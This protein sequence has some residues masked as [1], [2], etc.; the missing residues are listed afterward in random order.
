MADFWYFSKRRR[1][2]KLKRPFALL[3]AANH[4]QTYPSHP[5]MLLVRD[6][7]ELAHQVSVHERP[8]ACYRHCVSGIVRRVKLLGPFFEEIR[9]T[10]PPLPPSALLAFRSMHEFL[11]KC[12]LLVDSCSQSSS[13]TWAMVSSTETIQKFEVA[14]EEM[15]AALEV[16]PLSLLEISDEIKE[17]VLLLK[18]QSARGWCKALDPGQ[19]LLKAELCDLM[20][21]GDGPSSDVSLERLQKLFAG[22]GLKNW[23]DCK[24]E[25][26]GLLEELREKVAS[27]DKVAYSTLRGL[28][29]LVRSTARLLYRAGEEAFE[30]TMAELDGFKE[31]VGVLPDEFRCPISLELMRNPV[32]IATGQTYDKEHIQK[33]IAAGHFTCPTS[34][35]KLIHLGLIPNYALRS[36]IFHWCDDNNVSLEL[37]DAGFPDDDISNSREALE[38]AKTTSAF[39]VGKLATGSIDVQRQVAYELRLLAKNGTENRI[40]IAE[41]G[42]IPFLVP[43]LACNDSKTQENAVTALLNLSIYDNNKKLIMAANALDPILSVVEQ[44]LSMEARQNAAAAIFSLSSTDEH[45]IRIGSRAVA[46]PALVTLLLEGSLQ[47]KKDA[48]SA[49]FNLL[50]YPGNRARVV[51]AGAIEV[52]MAMLSKDGDVQDDALAVLALLGE[53]NEGLKAL[54][55][56][57]LAIPLLVNLLRTGSVKGKENSLSVLL[58]LCKHGGDMIRDCL[59]V[60]QQTQ[61]ESR[62]MSSGSSSALLLESLQELIASGSPRARRKARSLL[63]F[64]SVR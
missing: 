27:R 32:T 47:A 50:L 62:D 12:N 54:S 24:L 34:G 53:S 29:R 14:N 57:L 58:A 39:L 28:I 38:I 35:Q 11:A 41:A 37:F 31:R 5:G 9:D 61:Q 30:E 6:L 8:Q 10:N 55:D 43:L 44:G 26:T 2:M 22:L 3:H 25:L 13:I 36:L 1:I 17:H 15:A 52:L 33:W 45:R 63:K 4:H 60:E 20:E 49:L 40:C 23:S 56:D 42:A 48:T 7:I 59:M 16:I 51:N 21:R 46:I 18:L 19:E 64:L